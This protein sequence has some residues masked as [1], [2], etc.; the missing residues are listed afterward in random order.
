M[1]ESDSVSLCSK[2]I[3]KESEHW[4]S[5]EEKSPLG[6]KKRA[7]WECKRH[8]KQICQI[9]SDFD[10]RHGAWYSKDSGPKQFFTLDEY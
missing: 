4:I 7:P 2:E 6:K 9:L 5:K 10:E 3:A 1:T 8:M